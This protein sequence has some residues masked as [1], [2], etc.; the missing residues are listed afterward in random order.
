MNWTITA[1]LDWTTQYFEKHGIESPHLEAEILLAHCLGLK[2]IDLYVQHDRTLK[3]DELAAYKALIKRR[4][5]N[6]PSA[7][8]IGKKPFMSLDLKVTKDVLIPRPE[9][10]KLVETALELIKS[11]GKEKVCVL[12]IGTG[13][14]AISVSLAHY[15]KNAFLTATD[16]S[17]EAI[18]IAKENAVKYGVS[19]RIE[20]IHDNLFD[21]KYEGHKFDL[22]VSNP[23][24]IPSGKVKTLQPEIVNFEPI[25]ALDG[26]NDGLDFYRKIIGKSIVYIN[27]EGYL[28]LEIG[29]GQSAAVFEMIKVSKLFEEPKVYEDHGGI[30][31]VIV[32]R[33]VK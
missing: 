19:D 7:Y 22:V 10:E 29:I 28:V 11:V 32:G 2:R 9:T 5:D 23:P 13:S 3:E 16:I 8:I 30:E 15:A 33:R 1:L 18:E 12:D 25:H 17:K 24:Y 27:P 20:F 21:S 31:R 6:E 14:G 4:T 26:G